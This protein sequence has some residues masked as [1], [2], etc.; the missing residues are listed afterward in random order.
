[1]AACKPTAKPPV[2]TQ[3]ERSTEAKEV[4]S[5]EET[6]ETFRYTEDHSTEFKELS[7]SNHAKCW[8]GGLIVK[9]YPGENT[10]KLATLKENEQVEYL[11]QRT[12]R[13]SEYTF[14][15]QKFRDAWYLIKTDAGVIGWVHGGGLKFS[16]VPSTVADN[17]SGGSGSTQRVANPNPSGSIKILNDWVFVPGKRVGTISRQTTEEKLVM[18]FGPDKIKRGKVK[19]PGNKE[20]ACTFVFQGEPDEIAITWKDDTRT[21]IRAV[22]INNVGG[23]WHSQEGIKVGMPLA[24]LAKVNETPITFSGFDWEYGGT[25]SNWRKGNIEKFTKYFYVVLNYNEAKS[26]KEYLSQMKGDKYIHSNGEAAR[27]VDIQVKRI[28]VYVD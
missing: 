22:Y 11:Y 27:H 15:N 8:V 10:P 23:K 6:E 13:T 3:T 9:Q 19:V 12:A 16:E 28:V 1:M 4:A 14:R 17:E 26:S 20:E 7:R 18:L 24:D 25:I 2:E 5:P 21:K